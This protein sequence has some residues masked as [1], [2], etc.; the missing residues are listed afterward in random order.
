MV[1]IYYILILNFNSIGFRC[2][3][4]LTNRFIV[5]ARLEVSF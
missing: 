5:A 1:S 2:F 4:V 3:G